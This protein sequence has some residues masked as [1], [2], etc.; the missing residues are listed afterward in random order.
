M[1]KAFQKISNT[2]FM[3]SSSRPT[4][5]QEELI[6]ELQISREKTEIMEN[7]LAD[8]AEELEFLKKQV[9]QP[10]EPQKEILSMALEDLLEELRFTRWQMESL[11][12]SIDGALTR[13]FEKDEG[14]QLKDPGASHDTCPPTLGGSN[15][16][17]QTGTRRKKRYLESPPG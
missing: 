16:K 14:F 3:N 7:A 2:P 8:V 4:Q 5:D 17:Q 9:L 12:N 1:A 10:R 11:H 13:A 15:R 6:R